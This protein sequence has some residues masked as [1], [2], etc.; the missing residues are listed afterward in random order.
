MS[1]AVFILI[2][3]FFLQIGSAFEY[4]N[5]N[6]IFGIIKSDSVFY[7]PILGFFAFT[8]VPTSVSSYILVLI[9]LPNNECKYL[10]ITHI[11]CLGLFVV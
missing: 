9:L 10:V 3:R 7:V 11:F 5:Q 1:L 8:G 4:V 6:A 2:T